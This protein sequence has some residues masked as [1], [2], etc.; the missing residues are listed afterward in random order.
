MIDNFQ[1][2]SFYYFKGKKI[3]YKYIIDLL[4]AEEEEED[5]SV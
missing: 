3:R 2:L 1:K 5:I 4:P